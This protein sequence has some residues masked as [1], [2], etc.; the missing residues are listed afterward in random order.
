ME[1]SLIGI[2][3][4]E[5]AHPYENRDPRLKAY[6]LCDDDRG[7]NVMSKLGNHSR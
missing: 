5:A 7:W 2:T 1:R 6:V 4:I 3:P